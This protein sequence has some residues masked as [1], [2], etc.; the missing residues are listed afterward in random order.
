ME[1]LLDQ[2]WYRLAFWRVASDEINYRRFFDINDLAAIRVED[3]RVFDAVHRL[4]G[5]LLE[6][7]WVTGLRIDHPDGLRDPHSYFKNLQALYRSHQAANGSEASEV[8]IVAEKI[9]SGE[10]PLP[11]DW[12]V[13]GTT[14]YDLLNILGRVQVDGEGLAELSSFYDRETGNTRRP[15]SYRLRKPARGIVQQH[16]ERVANACGGAVPDRPKPSRFAAFHAARFTASITGSA[17]KHDCL[18]HL[19]PQR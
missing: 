5:Q 12:A 15:A 17:G 3:P 19:C 6:R 7:G 18:P 2:Q 1:A 9:L 13:C 16:A 14:G 4:V 11:S 8:Y 10:E